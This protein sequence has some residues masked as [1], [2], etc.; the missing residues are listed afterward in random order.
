[1]DGI[2][3]LGAHGPGE[4]PLCMLITGLTGDTLGNK[5]RVIMRPER[6]VP[7]PDGSMP[8]FY[9]PTQQGPVG[10]PLLPGGM[11]LLQG[12]S[13]PVLRTYFSER[14]MAALVWGPTVLEKGCCVCLLPA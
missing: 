7:E 1:M 10:K 13:F 8:S 3:R 14:W 6:N 2:I 5:S 9:I 4:E 11:C 12:S